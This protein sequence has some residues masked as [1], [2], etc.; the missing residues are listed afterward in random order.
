M[1]TSGKKGKIFGSRTRG[2]TMQT[3]EMQSTVVFQYR[4]QIEK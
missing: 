1:V 4:Q 3:K 2:I